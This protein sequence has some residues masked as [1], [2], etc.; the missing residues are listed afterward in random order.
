MTRTLEVHDVVAIPVEIA[1]DGTATYGRPYQT[2][3]LVTDEEFVWDCD[4]EEWHRPSW[5][6]GV[7][8]SVLLEAFNRWEPVPKADVTLT[9]TAEEADVLSQIL[10]LEELL[11]DDE[12]PR[13]YDTIAKKLDQARGGSR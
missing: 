3:A 7:P 4:A 8:E 12:D 1:D 11:D 2:D 9:L 6:E 10:G 13:D 5:V